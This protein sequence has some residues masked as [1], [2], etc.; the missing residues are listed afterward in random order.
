[1]VAANRS[2]LDHLS[3]RFDSD[4]DLILIVNPGALFR[5]IREAVRKANLLARGLT[6]NHLIRPRPS[7]KDSYK[8]DLSQLEQALQKS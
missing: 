4:D 7:R 3:Y 1:M 2:S 6:I 8:F 5:G